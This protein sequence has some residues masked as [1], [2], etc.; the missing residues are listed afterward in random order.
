MTS[1]LCYIP[2]LLL[3]IVQNTFANDLTK[4]SEIPLLPYAGKL[5]AIE[6]VIGEEKHRFLFDTAG[7][8]TIITPEVAKKIGCT[9]FGNLTVFRMDGSVVHFK[10]CGELKLSI[11]DANIQI[12]TAVFDLMSLFP[13]DFPKI[14]GIIS[15]H[16]LSNIPFT[17]ELSRNL[18]ILETE[19]SLQKRID[20]MN[21]LQMRVSRPSGGAGLDLFVAVKMDNGV[22]WFEFDSG[23][24]DSIIVSPTTAERME[25]P[26]IE[27]VRPVQI[28]GL[29]AVPIA[30]KEK[31]IIY[32]GTLN[33]AILEKFT[34]TIDIPT[35]RMWAR[36]N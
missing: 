17:L 29:S 18:L 1:L 26:S 14:S 20:G 30:V 11:G 28:S 27:N 33:A 9:Q 12:E 4:S 31:S 23:N 2:I 36:S 8:H 15:L 16:T 24:L 25:S 32:D 13:S 34:F 7:G 21:S 22:G 6:V 19:A 35:N 5:K 3:I 10:Q